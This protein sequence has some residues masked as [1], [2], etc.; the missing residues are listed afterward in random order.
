[1]FEDQVPS[2]SMVKN[3]YYYK[4]RNSDK[5]LITAGDSWTWG[6][7]LGKTKVRL[8][9]D[10]TEYRLNHIYGNILSEQLNCDWVNIALPGISNLKMLS[11][12]EEFLS[13][14]SKQTTVVITLTETG[15]HEE[16]RFVNTKLSTQQAVLESILQQTYIKINDLKLQYPKV[17]FVVAHNFTDPLDDAKV[18]TKTWLEVMSNEQRNHVHI[19]VSEHIQQ[20]NYNH[21]FPD[22]LDIMDRALTRI[23]QLDDCEFCNDGDT[24]HPTEQGHTMWAN[25][26]LENI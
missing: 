18:L 9:I 8:G 16:L 12:L 4:S 19:V 25:Y 17:K 14:N 10:D 13:Q 15:R 3:P 23:Q 1:M 22:V 20:M 5:L 6:D 7:S 26:L 2:W 11:W 24:R 21:T